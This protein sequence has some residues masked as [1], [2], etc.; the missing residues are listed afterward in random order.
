M[1]PGNKYLKVEGGTPGARR[2]LEARSKSG[3]RKV[4]RNMRD[5]CTRGMQGT[6]GT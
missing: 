1:Q 3:A 4:Y 5:R 2:E 6:R